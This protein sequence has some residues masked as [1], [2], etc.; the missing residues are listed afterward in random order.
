L[1]SLKFIPAFAM[2]FYA[3]HVIDKSDKRIF[4]CLAQLGILLL[5]IVGYVITSGYAIKNF[6]TDNILIVIFVRN[7]YHR[8]F[9]RIY[10]PPHLRC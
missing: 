9:A 7:I 8:H 2:A 6:Q 4:Y 10:G 1:A 5:M 3:G